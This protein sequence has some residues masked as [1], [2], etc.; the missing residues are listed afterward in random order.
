VTD[1]K[2]QSNLL[3]GLPAFSFCAIA[4]A[5][6]NNADDLAIEVGSM[7]EVVKAYEDMSRRLPR[8]T[9][10]FDSA[11]V[12]L[13]SQGLITV[14]DKTKITAQDEQLISLEN[15]SRKVVISSM[16]KAI[17]KIT[18][19]EES[20]ASLDQV[21]GKAAATYA[22]TRREAS[23]PGWWVQLSNGRWIQK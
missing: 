7:P 21:L 15:Q 14:K 4:H 2:P 8:I 23:K 10:L 18:K 6:E 12:G 3:N 13:T 1:G 20:K 17:L 16:A 19:V 9:M 11:A 5:A 22:D